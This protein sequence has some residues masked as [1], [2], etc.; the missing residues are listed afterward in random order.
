MP[1]ILLEKASTMIERA[2]M[3]FKYGGHLTG[4]DQVATYIDWIVSLPWDK[5]S[6]DNLDINNARQILDKY[7]YGLGE[8]KERILEYLSVMKLNTESANNNPL[9]EKHNLMR[10]PILFFVGLVGTGKTTIAKAISEAMDALLSGF[11]SGTG[12]GA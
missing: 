5:R 12:F 9:A 8:I 11:L 4:F 3:G 10:A 7:H 6:P 1:S 2:A